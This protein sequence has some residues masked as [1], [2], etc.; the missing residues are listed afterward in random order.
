MELR[1]DRFDLAPAAGSRERIDDAGVGTSQLP[2]SAEQP[3][4][5]L[6]Q[7]ARARPLYVLQGIK[8]HF[9][10]RD[11]PCGRMLDVH[12][13]DGIVYGEAALSQAFQ[14]LRIS[15]VIVAHRD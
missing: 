12:Y 11:W 4:E 8:E 13:K 1:L 3:L 14:Q 9:H 6:G 15:F 2:A 5:K 10:I 7:R